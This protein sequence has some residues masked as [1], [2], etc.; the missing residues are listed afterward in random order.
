MINAK[1]LSSVNGRTLEF[2]IPLDISLTFIP[3]NYSFEV[4]TPLGS[5]MNYTSKYAAV[6]ICCF[7]YPG[8]IDGI[9]EKGLSA[10]IFYFSGYASYSKLTK[11]N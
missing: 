9:N 10:G 7:D 6:G 1:D 11:D 8:L 5:G 3:R 2:G 4:K